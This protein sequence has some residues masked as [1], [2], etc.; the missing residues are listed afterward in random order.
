MKKTLISLVF[1]AGLTSNLFADDCSPLLNDLTNYA[2][3]TSDQV[4]CHGSYNIVRVKMTTNRAD[5]RFVSYAEGI[6]KQSTTFHGL[7]GDSEQYFSDRIANSS[8][9]DEWACYIDSQ[10]FYNKAKDTL[11][12]DITTLGQ[13]TFT[14]K[15]WGNGESSIQTSCSN[16][17]MYSTDHGGVYTFYTFSF[18]KD[19]LPGDPC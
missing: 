8:H 19:T 10:P 14:L 2:S 5:S 7:T 4:F 17:V 3:R 9:C 15:S 11:G 16:G 18:V 6:L 13:V 1:T 12:L